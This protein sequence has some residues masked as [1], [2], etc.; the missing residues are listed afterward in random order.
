MSIE[1][2]IGREATIFLKKVVRGALFE[3]MS[4]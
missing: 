1:E 3:D 4:D 2:D